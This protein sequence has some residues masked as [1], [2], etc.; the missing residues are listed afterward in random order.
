M[1]HQSIS[2]RRKS[3]KPRQIVIHGH[4]ASFRLEP[5]F[6][7]YLRSIAAEMGVSLAKLVEAVNMARNPERNLS[8]ALRVFIARHFYE[9]TPHFGL[10]DPDSSFSIRITRPSKAALAAAAVKADPGKSDRALAKEIGVSDFTVRQARNG[11][12][13]T[14]QLKDTLRIGL[15]GKRRKM[16]ERPSRS[17]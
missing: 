11:L 15:D 6:W 3:I 17:S 1:P 12:R 4:P 13:E 8:S 10:F 9:T 5:E 7:F 2:S 16:P 14:L